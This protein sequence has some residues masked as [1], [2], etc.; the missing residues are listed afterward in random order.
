MIGCAESGC[1]RL[2]DGG[3][4][5][6]SRS[7]LRSAPLAARMRGAEPWPRGGHV[8]R[9]GA[10]ARA[11]RGGG[12]SGAAGASPA[13]LCRRARRPQ[14]AWGCELCHIRTCACASLYLSSLARCCRTLARRTRAHAAAGRD[15]GAGRAA[16]QQ[17]SGLARGA[18]AVPRGSAPGGAR[19]Y[20]GG[21]RRRSLTA[22]A[23]VGTGAG[24]GPAAP[25]G[26]ER[27]SRDPPPAAALRL[28]ARI[29]GGAR[30]RCRAVPCGAALYVSVC[31]SACLSAASRA[32]P[33]LHTDFSFPSPSLWPRRVS[34][35]CCAVAAGAG[36][37]RGSRA[38]V[39]SL[40]ALHGKSAM[41][42]AGINS[43]QVGLGCLSRK[44]K[45]V[46]KRAL[47]LPFPACE[48][49]SVTS[50]AA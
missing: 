20:V 22:G 19:A 17:R 10:A 9:R 45:V 46:P 26:G 6:R 23:A 24:C 8:A 15:C 32:A 35:F 40:P 39:P 11:P 3:G 18:A 28:G 38:G 7:P 42:S 29:G 37:A 14:P 49:G 36:W 16:G 1:S 43:A 33:S 30:A 12:G 41:A 31:L 27:E 44:V 48:E 13:S 25:R 5:P 50:L 4:A 34:R 2:R 47:L 21:D